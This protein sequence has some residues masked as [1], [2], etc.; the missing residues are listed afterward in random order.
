MPSTS[1][2]DYSTVVPA[3]WLNE[4][5]G[6][7]W[8]LF[9]ATTTAA[10]GRTALGLG[11]IS[12]QASSN[13]SI[14]GGSISGITDLAVADGGTGASDAATART[15]LGVPAAANGTHTGTTNVQTLAVSVA[16]TAPTK[17]QAD[18]TTAV[19]TT[20]FIQ[21]ARVSK[22]LSIDASVA[23]NA[24]TVTLNPCVLDFRSTST[25]NGTISTRLVPTAI[26]ATVPNGATLGTNNSQTTRIFL[27]A[28]DNAGTVELAIV[29]VSGGVALDETGT[30]N[31]TAL[32][33][34][35]DSAAVIYSTSAR[36]GV[37]YRIVG[38]I[39]STQTTAGTWAT[40]PSK[41]Q[42]IGGQEL[43][44]FGFGQTWQTV[45]RNSGTTYYN[46]TGYPIM[47]SCSAVWSAAS[48]VINGVT[49]AAPSTTQ[50]S[51]ITFVVPPGAAYVITSSSG[52]TSSAELRT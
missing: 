8:T 15:N 16:A 2:T 41:I 49:I 5:N 22:I 42:G 24:L 48:I 51:T 31:T 28:I 14:T 11:T 33:T 18:S 12:T 32:T 4:V 3:T 52:I 34:A 44:T 19:A 9:G 46:T 7:V 1:F 25:S 30:I 17:T 36:T 29:N 39:E 35:S 40:A 38:F 23:G 27:V 13:V 47:V 6:V 43:A 20:E 50:T 10:G 26:T 37:A 21:S 45:T